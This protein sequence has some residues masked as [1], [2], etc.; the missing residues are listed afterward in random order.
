MSV[1]R[2]MERS[3]TQ[4]CQKCLKHGHYT[5]ECKNERSYTFRPSA[6]MIHKYLILSNPRNQNLQKDLVSEKPPKRP[7]VRDDWK[8][9]KLIQGSKSSSSSKLSS[10]S[11]NSSSS[12]SDSNSVSSSSNSGSKSSGSEKEL[13]KEEYIPYWYE[14]KFYRQE[15]KTHE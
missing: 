8:R 2:N 11:S 10:S 7:K 9:S 15:E 14:F 6:T 1:F 12:D 13:E 4:Q 5:F 3:G